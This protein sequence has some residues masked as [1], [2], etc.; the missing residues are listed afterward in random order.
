MKLLIKKKQ[1][2][3]N[4]QEKHEQ[5]KRV[6]IKNIYFLFLIKIIKKFYKYFF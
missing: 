3:H 1:F 5:E 4:Q 6:L 2:Y